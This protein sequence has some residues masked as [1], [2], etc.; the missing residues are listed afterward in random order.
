MPSVLGDNAVADLTAGG[1][2][3]VLAQ[4]GLRVA[5]DDAAQY[6]RAQAL[7][8]AVWGAE[9]PREAMDGGDAR[10]AVYRSLLDAS[11][12]DG[13]RLGRLADLLGLWGEADQAR[14][15]DLLLAMAGLPT[16]PDALWTARASNPNT[17]LSRD[18][19]AAVV[20]VLAGH[21]LRYEAAVYA[22]AARDA[23]LIT[24]AAKDLAGRPRDAE[25][26]AG[27]TLAV[28]ALRHCAPALA[29]LAHTPVYR[30]VVRAAMA[31]VAY[32][33]LRIRATD[34]GV[35]N[36]AAGL[37]HAGAQAAAADIACE[38]YGYVHCA[39]LPL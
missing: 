10:A 26:L 14:W 31:G 18:D 13:G 34:L 5:E 19:D 30:A 17:G 3:H 8:R 7:V 1:A 16:V 35:A 24:A 27:S 9:L 21:G 32:R 20:A 12:A 4:N 22:C 37:V 23:N 39:L 33:P 36:I 29:L 28:E 6:Y 15:R 25:R 38:Y 2:G 11:A